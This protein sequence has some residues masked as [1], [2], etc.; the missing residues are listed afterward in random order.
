MPAL[1]RR[2]VGPALALL[3]A[4]TVA[5]PGAASG[6]RRQHWVPPPMLTWY[7]QLQGPIDNSVDAAVYDV[8]AFDTPSWE[9]ARLHA[10]GRRVVCYLDVGTWESWRPDASRFPRSVL[11]RPDAGWPGERWLDIRDMTVLRPIMLA[12]LRLCARKGFDGVEPDNIEEIGNDSGFP[13][14][15]DEQLRY[16]EWIAAAAHSQ[17]LA[18]FQKND[19]QQA[20]VLE[21]RFDGA[22]VEQCN[23]YRECSAFYPYLRAHKPVLNA[24]Y[25]RSLYPSFCAADMRAGIMG[26]LYNLELD[27]RL[28]RPCW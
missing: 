25:E 19:P 6:A 8:D 11:G 26:A 15:R 4:A 2:I 14:T 1:K 20:R 9:V 24:E 5:A 10:L 23:E 27:G 22:L 12:R 7:W 28:F 13:I 18:V 21:P 17:G 16:A 3:V